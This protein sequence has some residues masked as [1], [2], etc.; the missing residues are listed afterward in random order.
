MKEPRKEQTGTIELNF[1]NSSITKEEIDAK[2]EEMRNTMMP[3]MTKLHQSATGGMP[4]ADT[5]G[6]P[7]PSD[8]PTIE[9]VD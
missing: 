5:G 4:G 8:I 9:E 2:Q 7:D 3:I 6:M 1:N